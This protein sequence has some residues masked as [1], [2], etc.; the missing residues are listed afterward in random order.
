MRAILAFYF[1]FAGTLL[2]LGFLIGPNIVDEGRSLM[3]N[4][5]ALVDRMTSGQF[6]V[7]LGH[8]QG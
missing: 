5:P 7:T 2:G 6:I 3:A 1:L 4:L 8:N